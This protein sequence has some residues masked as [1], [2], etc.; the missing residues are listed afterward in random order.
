M[1]F[2]GQGLRDGHPPDPRFSFAN[3]RT[4]L[5]WNRTGLALIGGG[6]LAANLLE[7]LPTVTGLL[8]VLAPPVLGAACAV[9]GFRRWCIRELQLRRREPLLR[10][11]RAGALL[12]AATAVLAALAIGVTVWSEVAR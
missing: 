2:L 6:L 7:Q 1:T 12:A 8:L 5:A 10:A 11:S 3:E 4:Y 9:S